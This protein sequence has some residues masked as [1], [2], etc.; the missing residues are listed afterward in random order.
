MKAFK[1]IS[2][3][4]FKH[5]VMTFVIGAI[6]L[7]AILDNGQPTDDLARK[8]QEFTPA[9]RGV[10][11]IYVNEAGYD[12]ADSYASVRHVWDKGVTLYCYGSRGQH[13]EFDIV[14]HGGRMSVTSA[15]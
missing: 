9:E 12:C 15:D 6:I 2:E 14:D 10:F 4:P 13:Y 7:S 8:L 1:K 3:F 5:P 11:S